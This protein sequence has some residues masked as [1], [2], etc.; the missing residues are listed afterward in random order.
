MGEELHSPALCTFR[1]KLAAVTVAGT[2][3][4]NGLVSKSLSLLVVTVLIHLMH[5]SCVRFAQSV[6]C[7]LSADAPCLLAE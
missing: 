6:T 5:Y 1:P 4:G 3:P 7:S 2:D